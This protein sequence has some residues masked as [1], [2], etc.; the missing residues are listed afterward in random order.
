MILEKSLEPIVEINW[1]WESLGKG[2]T[3]LAGGREG[4]VCCRV[5][6]ANLIV[7]SVDFGVVWG[8]KDES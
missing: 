1:G 6:R 4:V 3:E 8:T 5:D 2:E 7:A